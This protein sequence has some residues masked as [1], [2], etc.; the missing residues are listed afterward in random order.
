MALRFLNLRITVKS[1]SITRE[2]FGVPLLFGYHE[3]W[4]SDFVREY[5][6]AAELLDDGFDTDHYLYKAALKV[7]SQKPNAPKTFKIGRRETAL[8]QIINIT[9][10]VTTVGY[11]HAGTVDDKAYAYTVLDGDDLAAIC[12][13]VASAI[14]ALSVGVTADGSSGTEVVCTADDAG[15]VHSYEIGK[16]SELLDATTDTTTDNDL[17]NVFDEDFNWYGLSVLD[18]GSKATGELVAE[19]IEAYRKISTLQ[20]ADDECGDADEDEDL[21][22]SLKDSNYERTGTIYHRKI[23]GSECLAL[24]WMAGALT[25]TP[26][27][28]TW[29]F[30]S[31]TGVTIDKLKTGFES[32]ILAK[33]GNVYDDE[34]GHTWEG[35]TASGQYFDVIRGVDWLYSELVATVK[36]FFETNDKVPYTNDG[37]GLLGSAIENV[38]ERASKAPYNLLDPATTAVEVG[39]IEDQSDLDRQARVFPAISAAPRLQ[40]AIHT[41]DPLDILISV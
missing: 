7:K 8:T 12:T 30:K 13:G 36:L 26:G 17:A 9:P 14:S 29:A 11:K 1:K 22:S 19:T 5:S 10:T 40:G 27:S 4:L 32:A 15:A 37:A 20:T 25:R 6:E 35:K 28:D 23:G 39:K 2:S 34:Q 33:N 31:P 18:S 21:L 38:L 24:A 16:G 41:L 3:A